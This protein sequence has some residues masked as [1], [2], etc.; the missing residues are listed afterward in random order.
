[1]SQ[2]NVEIVQRA[3]RAINGG[4]LDALRDLVAADVEV[5]ASAVFVDQG[6]FRGPDGLTEFIEGLRAIWGPSFRSQPE[7]VIEHEDRVLVT[8]RASGTGQ[9]SGVPAETVRTHVWTIRDGKIARF[10]TFASRA[11]A[12]EAAGLRE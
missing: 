3:Y 1:M 10:K 7:E 2:E 9:G 5:D 8:A 4:D 6:T 12:L 11:E